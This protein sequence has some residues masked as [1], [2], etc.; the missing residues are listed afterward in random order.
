MNATNT[1]Y[2]WNTKAEAGLFVAVVSKCT[3]RNEAN[4]TGSYCDTK[5]V[6]M[7]QFS[8]RARAVSY[9]KKMVRYYGSNRPAATNA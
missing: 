8:T 6:K 9:A 5:V 7:A 3:S 2:S 1:F 4:E